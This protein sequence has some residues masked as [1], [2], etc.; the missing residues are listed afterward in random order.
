MH[1]LETD[2]EV[3]IT[4]LQQFH[5]Q[6]VNKLR[7]PGYSFTSDPKHKQSSSV[8]FKL[9]A[10]SKHCTLTDRPRPDRQLVKNVQLSKSKYRCIDKN[11]INLSLSR[12]LTGKGAFQ[13]VLG[14]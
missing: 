10:D 14:L 13:P 2:T 5:A 6:A 12:T 11:I 8:V 7:D 4:P 1:R 3:N 9:Q